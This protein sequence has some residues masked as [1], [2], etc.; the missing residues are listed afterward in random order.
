MLVEGGGRCAVHC[1]L[2]FLQKRT[3]RLEKRMADG[4]ATRYF[5]KNVEVWSRG[6]GLLDSMRK[7]SGSK[8]DKCLS[9]RT[10]QVRFPLINPQFLCFEAS[11]L[12]GKGGTRKPIDVEKKRPESK[13]PSVSKQSE[14]NG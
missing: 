4:L 6:L 11:H 8:V 2:I 13:Q 12:V 1:S 10:Y 7:G 14:R 9:A 5:I 3:R